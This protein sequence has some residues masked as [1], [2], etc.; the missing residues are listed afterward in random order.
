MGSLHWEV[1]AAK[2][3][4]PHSIVLFQPRLRV[5]ISA[6]AL[7]ENGFGI[8]F[9]ELDGESAF[10][11]VSQTLDVIERLQPATVIPGH[12]A[13]FH[14]LATAL[15]RARSRLHQFSTQPEKHRRHAHK[16]LIK[17]KLLEWQR[18]QAHALH[19]W[20][21]QTP[22][23]VRDMPPELRDDVAASTQWLN[24]LLSELERAQALR[25]E[26][27]WILNL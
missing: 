2:G 22:Y 18:V 16:V 14:D 24:A 20:V 11:D 6:D 4:D 17:F 1:H 21:M 25:Q 5:L 26:G 8:V 9:P 10:E 19:A 27:D 23:F 13:V 12:G 15:N 3:H 7:W